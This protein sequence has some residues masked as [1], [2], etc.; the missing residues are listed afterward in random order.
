MENNVQKMG[1]ALKMALD[2]LKS[3]DK[4]VYGNPP[5]GEALGWDDMWPSEWHNAQE[6][7]EAAIALPLRQ[8]DVGTAEEQQLRFSQ[9]CKSH[10]HECGLGRRHANCPAYKTTDCALT[11]AQMPYEEG[12]EK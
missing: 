8:C 1:N 4:Y 9:F 6:A 2:A 10:V 12:A 5:N 11:W 3:A 7:V